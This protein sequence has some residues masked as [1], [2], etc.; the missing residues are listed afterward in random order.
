MTLLDFERAAD[1]V[2][3]AASWAYVAGGADTQV[4]VRANVEAFDQVWLRPRALGSASDKPD[5]SVT[6]FEQRLALPVLL[7]PTSPQRLLHDDAEMAT[8]RAAEA[9]GTVSIVSTDSHHA[10][11]EVARSVGSDCWFQLYAYRSREDVAATIT[12]AEE[13]GATALVVTVDASYA[14]RRITTRRAGFRTPAHVDFGNLRSLGILTGAIPDGAR[15]ERLPLTWDDL[16]WIRSRTGMRLVVKGILRAEDAERCLDLGADGVIVSNHGGRQLD[17]A[18][19]SLVA[20]E[21]VAATVS[22]RGTVLMDGGIRSGVHVVKALAL[23]ADAVCIGRP[24]LWGLGLAGQEGIEAVLGLLKD[25][26]EDTL[27]QLGVGSIADLGP[28]FTTRAR[29][30]SG[31][32]APLA[33]GD[34]L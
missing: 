9:T 21:Q 19:P 26:I 33:Q 4:T 12:L 10:F 22:G 11:P 17:G 16:E 1:A 6:V 14:A 27:L 23:G 13:A 30:G 8:A 7:A 32:V 25:E 3:D 29:F 2:L 24:Y 15:I 28:D 5:T 34:D 31:P 18:L 20:L